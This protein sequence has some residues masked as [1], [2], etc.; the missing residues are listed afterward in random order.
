ME[1]KLSF[2]EVL[3]ME[4]LAPVELNAIVG[5]TKDIKVVGANG[6]TCSCKDTTENTDQTSVK[7]P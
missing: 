6:Y 4:E 3:P 5:G 7:K 2:N 1:K